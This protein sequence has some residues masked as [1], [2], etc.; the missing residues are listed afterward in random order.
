[1]SDDD[2]GI[3][4][5]KLKMTDRSIPVSVFTYVDGPD[6]RQVQW[7]LVVPTTDAQKQA[8]PKDF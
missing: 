1:M 3:N 8:L 4:K 7:T 5:D 2:D 6:G